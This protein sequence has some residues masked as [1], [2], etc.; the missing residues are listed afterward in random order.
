[1]YKYCV[2]VQ[3]NCINLFLNQHIEKI[4]YVTFIMKLEV[5]SIRKLHMLAH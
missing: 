1:M 4:I 5:N 3:E 2:K